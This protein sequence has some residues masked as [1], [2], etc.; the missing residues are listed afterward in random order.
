MIFFPILLLHI[1]VLF[2]PFSVKTA[3]PILGTYT[4]G[5]FTLNLSLPEQEQVFDEIKSNANYDGS[6]I[7]AFIEDPDPTNAQS[8]AYVVFTG[9]SS[10]SGGYNAHF[11]LTKNILGN[12]VNYYMDETS[13]ARVNAG[14]CTGSPCTDCKGH[15]NWFLGPISSC[16]C[17]SG[18]QGGNCN[19]TQADSLPWW[20]GIIV[21]IVTILAAEP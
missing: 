3:S 16:T 19:H 7:R 2:F 13:N 11:K 4:S 18:Q 15:R 5:S 21:L 9:G 14:T 17:E 6:F 8:Q 10:R 20:W 1:I 12:T